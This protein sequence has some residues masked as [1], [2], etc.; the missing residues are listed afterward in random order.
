M[1]ETLEQIETDENLQEEH[2]TRQLPTGI[3]AVDL[4]KDRETLPAVAVD[5]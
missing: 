5:N 1:A 4:K 3:G 2:K